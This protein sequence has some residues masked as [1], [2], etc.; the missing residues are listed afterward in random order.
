[1]S[2]RNRNPASVFKGY[3]KKYGLTVGDYWIAY[4]EQDGQC[5][6]CGTGIEP[7]AVGRRR[8]SPHQH[9]RFSAYIDHNHETNEFRGLLCVRCN[10]GLGMFNDDPNLLVAAKDYL[11]HA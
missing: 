1:M 3:L 8:L 10:S 5:K 4:V 6:I 11:G 7:S 9:K 2:M